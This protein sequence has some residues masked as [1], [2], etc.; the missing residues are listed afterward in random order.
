MRCLCR[1]LQTLPFGE[2][3]ENV[4]PLPSA[5]TLSTGELFGRDGIVVYTVSSAAAP[6]APKLG[7]MVVPRY[8]HI[9]RLPVLSERAAKEYPADTV[10]SAKTVKHCC[11]VE[12]CTVPQS[13]ESLPL[14]P[15][16]LH[17][18][19]ALLI[20]VL[21]NGTET[22]HEMEKMLDYKLYQRAERS[23]SNGVVTLRVYLYPSQEAADSASL[24]T[25]QF[26]VKH[27]TV[28]MYVDPTTLFHGKDA[29]AVLASIKAK[30]PRTTASLDE[31]LHALSADDITMVFDSQA[32]RDA[33]CL[34]AVY[35][36]GIA[37]SFEL[38]RSVREVMVAFGATLKTASSSFH[39]CREAAVNETFQA[40]FK[41]ARYSFKHQQVTMKEAE[42][43]LPRHPSH[44]A[45]DK[46]DT[47]HRALLT[48]A[49]NQ[50]EG[51][52]V[53]RG[54]GMSG[55]HSIVP[56]MPFL[57]GSMDP[58]LYGP[59]ANV[60]AATR[61][62]ML[63]PV[64]KPCGKLHTQMAA[65]ALTSLINHDRKHN[66]ESYTSDRAAVWRKVPLMRRL[67]Y[68]LPAEEVAPLPQPLFDD[69]SDDEEEED[70]M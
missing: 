36:T 21:S 26:R 4:K 70:E 3:P 45:R 51:V 60:M 67:L 11:T 2:L 29:A 27:D 9:L 34:D 14:L 39:L 53:D 31:A 57:E 30:K 56:V 62:G 20:D 65:M 19:V 32:A 38:T 54:S 25:L 42:L 44:A 58:Q 17:R 66:N 52:K 18:S 24:E 33:V 23:D 10:F 47:V 28:E 16:C 64:D 49:L 69:A 15:G 50:L 48:V 55:Y 8:C 7:R 6:G 13:I 35:D 41:T 12:T 22:V 68:G 1:S 5:I 59:V 43:H 37:A 46:A 61:N 63:L 40:L